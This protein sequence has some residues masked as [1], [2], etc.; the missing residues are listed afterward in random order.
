M[1]TYGG[2]PST[3]SLNLD[4][5]YP[6]WLSVSTL[7]PSWRFLARWFGTTSGRTATSTSAWGRRRASLSEI[8]APC[9]ASRYLWTSWGRQED[10]MRRGVRFVVDSERGRSI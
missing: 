4:H 6:G 7:G 5:F 3:T 2:K 9:S 8:C 1:T 10:M